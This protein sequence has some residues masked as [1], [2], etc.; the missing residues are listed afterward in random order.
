MTD[1]PSQR[2]LHA[3]PIIICFASC[4]SV[5]LLFAFYIFLLLFILFYLFLICISEANLFLM[6]EFLVE[7]FTRS[8]L[9]ALCACI[10]LTNG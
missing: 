7:V 1:S 6:F 4:Y 5:E 2:T 9:L 3:I 8:I 10:L